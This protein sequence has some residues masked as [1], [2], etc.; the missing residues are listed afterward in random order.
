MDEIF[1]ICELQNGTP[2]TTDN[3]LTPLKDILKSEQV[4]ATITKQ[5]IVKIKELQAKLNQANE[6]EEEQQPAEEDI[7][8]VAG[9]GTTPLHAIVSSVDP[10]I[11]AEE[12]QVIE[13]MIDTLFE[14]G[15]GWMIGK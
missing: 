11:S 15:A 9:G 1:K 13:S 4:P 2:I 5:D 8:D 6:N 10:S 12:L 14:W 7:E 3:Y